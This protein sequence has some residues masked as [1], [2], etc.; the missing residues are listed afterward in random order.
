MNWASVA[1]ITSN[2]I[3]GIM[4]VVDSAEKPVMSATNVYM[5]CLDQGID[6]FRD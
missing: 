6:C 2:R 1:E 3:C 4:F 5:P